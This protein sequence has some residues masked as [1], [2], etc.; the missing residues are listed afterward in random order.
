[1][2]KKT[3]YDFQKATLQHLLLPAALSGKLAPKRRHAQLAGLAELPTSKA[4]RRRAWGRKPTQGKGLTLK[5]PSLVTT[6]SHREQCFYSL[7]SPRCLKSKEEGETG[8]AE[9]DGEVR[10]FPQIR[11]KCDRH[12]G[13]EKWAWAKSGCKKVKAQ[14]LT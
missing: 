1:M 11:Q 9:A 2:C 12:R 6:Q 13:T 4:A 7:S 14:I 8:R 3:G 5:K 10:Q